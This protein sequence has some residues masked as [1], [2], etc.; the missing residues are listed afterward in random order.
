MYINKVA[1]KSFYFI[2]FCFVIV[3]NINNENTRKTYFL[4]YIYIIIGPLVSAKWLY[5]RPLNV[6]WAELAL[7]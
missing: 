6:L 2:Y 7:K 4:C 5:L 3:C 1:K